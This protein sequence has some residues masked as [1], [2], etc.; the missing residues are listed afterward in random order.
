[1]SRRFRDLINLFVRG[2]R[3]RQIRVYPRGIIVD[4]PHGQTGVLSGELLHVSM[5]GILNVF[6]HGP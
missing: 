6:G 3:H 4:Q 2:A 1:M 5:D